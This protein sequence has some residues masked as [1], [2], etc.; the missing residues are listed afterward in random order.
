MRVT[1][2]LENIRFQILMRTPEFL[3]GMFEHLVSRRVSLNN[4]EQASQLIELGRQHISQGA[5]ESLRHSR[6]LSNERR[7]VVYFRAIPP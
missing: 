4:P 6:A 3:K 1:A 7:L 2:D 5:W